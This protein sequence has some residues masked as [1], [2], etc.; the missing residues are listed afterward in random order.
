MTHPFNRTE[1]N[2]Y[3]PLLKQGTRVQFILDNLPNK[4]IKEGVIDGVSSEPITLGGRGYII[5]PDEQIG[6]YK[7]ISLLE[8]FIN[9]INE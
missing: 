4:E 6:D 9:P 2:W 1:K 8:L 5:K 3:L 7:S